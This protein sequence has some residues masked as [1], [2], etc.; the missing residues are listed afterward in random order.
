MKTMK[1][2]DR[3]NASMNFWLFLGMLT[4]LTVARK[5]AIGAEV[6]FLLD[7]IIISLEE[8]LQNAFFSYCRWQSNYLFDTQV[9]FLILSKQKGRKN[10]KIV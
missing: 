5:K 4:R 10:S 9:F 1:E 8:M 7:I 6:F 2:W 3:N